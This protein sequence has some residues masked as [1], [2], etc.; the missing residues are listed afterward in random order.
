MFG[1]ESLTELDESNLGSVS[2]AKAIVILAF[3]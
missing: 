3:A 2:D 1:A